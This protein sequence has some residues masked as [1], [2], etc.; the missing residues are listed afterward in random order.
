MKVHGRGQK[1]KDIY[2]VK[3][4]KRFSTLKVKYG[5]SKVEVSKKSEQIYH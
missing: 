3:L 1:M 4:Y 2:I 5:V